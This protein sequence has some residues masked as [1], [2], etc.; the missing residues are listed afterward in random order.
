ML[1]LAQPRMQRLARLVLL[2]VPL[3]LL[4]GQLLVTPLTQLPPPLLR[5]R[6]SSLLPP[7]GPLL[8]GWSSLGLAQPEWSPSLAPPSAARQMACGQGP[9]LAA[10]ARKHA[11]LKQQQP[12]S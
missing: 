5:L 1:R 2:L 9:S 7:L 3:A 10:V 6:E 8:L 4:P 12:L 11:Q